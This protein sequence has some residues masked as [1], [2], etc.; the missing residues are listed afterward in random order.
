MG[1]TSSK[2]R[3]V[4]AVSESNSDLKTGMESK[5]TALKKALPADVAAGSPGW[6]LAYRRYPIFSAPWVIR[7]ALLFGLFIVSWGALSGLGHYA[8]GRSAI[9]S[10]QLFGW[11]VLATGIIVNAGP[12]LAALVRHRG[13]P[14]RRER[15]GVLVAMAFGLVVAF[16]ADLITSRQIAALA[17]QSFEREFTLPA[18][19]LN[20]LVLLTIYLLIGGGLA[21][22]A[23][24]SEARRLAEFRQRQDMAN[25]KADK[26]ATD[27]QLAL[28]QAQIEPHFLFNT[29]ATIRSDLRRSPDQAEQ[30]LDALCAYLRAAIPRLRDSDASDQS[31]LGDQLDICRHYLE[32]MQ[33]RMRQRL[34]FTIEVAE[35]LVCA[36]FPPFLLLSLVENAIRHGVEPLPEGGRI[37]IS[38][39]HQ[40]DDSARLT[41]SV[42]DTGVGLGESIGS[43]V[44]LNNIRD[45]LRLRYADQARLI[46]VSRREG[47]VRASIQLPLEKTKEPSS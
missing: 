15:I 26:L 7:R 43:G 27:Q 37:S 41:V 33:G 1:W 14:L 30:T 34:E 9:S 12:V 5:T 44:G 38:A 19:T 8:Q 29:L 22:R 28:L 10:L 42:S 46:L 17:G 25:L 40:V 39:Q 36:G 3:S 32:V 35:D 16:V 21:L 13:W 6:W 24:F 23:Y 2:V 31:T 20:L 47:G 4:C 18:L 11:F 45:Q